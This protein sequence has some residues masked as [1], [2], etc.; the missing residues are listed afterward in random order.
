MKVQRGVTPSLTTAGFAELA[1]A[2]T[3]SLAR[4]GSMGN[5]PE[6]ACLWQLS[7]LSWLFQLSS[8]R[9]ITTAKNDEFPLVVLV[10]RLA[11]NNLIFPGG[12]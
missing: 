2:V 9:H 12:Q 4:P 1:Q 5:S 10:A 3:S 11:E 8:N 6:K 7:R